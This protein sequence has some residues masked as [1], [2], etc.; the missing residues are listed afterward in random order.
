MD[1]RTL[2][3]SGGVKI[4]EITDEFGVDTGRSVNFN[5]ADEGFAED[6]YGLAAKLEQIQQDYD[7]RYAETEDAAN[8]FDISRGKDR[9]MREAVDFLFGDGFSDD[10]FKTRMTALSDGMTVVENFLFSLLDEMDD[11]INA[12]IAARDAR[13][14]EY[15]AKYSK[16]TKKYH[17]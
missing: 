5:P 16:Y 3:V 4:L 9:A 6:L 13:I 15:T 12:N 2:V 11:T 17:N 8:R 10:V 14:K 7:K 1:N